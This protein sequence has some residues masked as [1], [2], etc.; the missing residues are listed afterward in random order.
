MTEILLLVALLGCQASPVDP[1]R[2]VSSDGPLV[3]ADWDEMLEVDLE[4]FDSTE[5][6]RANRSVFATG[7]LNDKQVFLDKNVAYTDGGLTKSMR[8]DWVNQGAKSVSVGRGIVLPHKVDELW[9]ELV[10]RWSR[11]YTPCNPAS[12]PCAHKL[13]FFQVS[14]DGNQRWDVVVGGAGEAGPEAHMTMNAAAGGREGQNNN[15]RWELVS[16]LK[17]LGTQGPELDEANKYFDEQW[18]V[19]RLHAKHS[20]NRK[21]FDGRMRLWMDGVRLYDSEELRTKHGAAG[22]ATNDDTKIRAILIGRNK[23]KGL[24]NG[25]ESVWIGRVRAWRE[26]PG[27]Q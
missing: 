23:D 19:L 20:T 15:S 11:N 8:Y 14:P 18:H 1:S 27:W 25:T 2:N 10:V 7:N 3:Q 12:P 22:F 16:I 17:T 26:D 9:V 21:T 4:G 6:L 5:Q 13:L 24:D